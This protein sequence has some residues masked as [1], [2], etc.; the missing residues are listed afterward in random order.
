MK[1]ISD[2][3]FAKR[4]DIITWLKPEN[5]FEHA[6]AALMTSIHANGGRAIYANDDVLIDALFE[7]K[8]NLKPVYQ[9]LEKVIRT[10]VDEVKFHHEKVICLYCTT[11]SLLLWQ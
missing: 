8:E 3:G 4:N 1:A 11:V 5:G 7:K 9:A 6:N 10:E 2:R